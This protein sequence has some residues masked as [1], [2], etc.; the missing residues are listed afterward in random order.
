MQGLLSEG[1]CHC[2]V[3]E[4]VRGEFVGLV[5][6]LLAVLGISESLPHVLFD[7]ALVL[8]WV[9]ISHVVQHLPNVVSHVHVFLG[10]QSEHALQLLRYHC[11]NYSFHN[12]Y[13][14][15]P[16]GK[17]R[18]LPP[19]NDTLFMNQFNRMFHSGKEGLGKAILR[20]D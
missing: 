13:L 10:S 18:I 20:C 12:I 3:D 16:Q 11:S 1:G 15:Q 17:H 19:I 7:E 8:L 14:D 2:E 9:R 6:L 5:L 4:R